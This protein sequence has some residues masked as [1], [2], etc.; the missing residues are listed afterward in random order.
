MN[1]IDQD[2]VQVKRY[3]QGLGNW[4]TA[5]NN[6]N[7]NHNTLVTLYD[8]NNNSINKRHW[9][10]N[11]IKEYF[12]Q[13]KL[14][15][16]HRINTENFEYDRLVISIFG[17][18]NGK[19][20]IISSNGELVNIIDDIESQFNSIDEI[21]YKICIIDSCCNFSNAADNDN[22]VGSDTTAGGGFVRLTA[23]DLSFG[24]NDCVEHSI[25]G[26]LFTNLLYH[27]YLLS[28][29]CDTNVVYY[30][31]KEYNNNDDGNS[32]L[33]VARGL[34][35]IVLDNGKI[36]V[37]ITQNDNDNNNN[38]V[39]RNGN[40]KINSDNSS[41]RDIIIDS[42]HVSSKCDSLSYN[43]HLV[44]MVIYQFDNLN[45]WIFNNKYKC[46]SGEIIIV[47][48]NK[49]IKHRMHKIMNNGNNN[50]DNSNNNNNIKNDHYI[51]TLA[52]RKCF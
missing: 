50:K 24:E 41:Y 51:N 21:K 25:K 16:M 26:G 23:S 31:Y 52:C 3:W 1:G 42:F 27:N 37:K 8:D 17:H 47:D 11:E 19:H 13:A 39:I 30:F 48:K 7:N 29:S 28:C 34:K 22:G 49:L 4:N 20:C 9:N 14:S 43:K 38:G 12:L 33:I 45:N 2:I 35:K 46:K 6:N 44:G 18:G 15:M 5:S 32:N 36:K 40:V 10:R